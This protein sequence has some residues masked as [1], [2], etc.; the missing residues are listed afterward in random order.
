MR[1][2]YVVLLALTAFFTNSFAQKGNNQLGGGGD[3]SIPTGDFANEFKTGFGFYLKGLLGVGK[4]G[5]ITL[6]SGFSAFKESGE[7]D[8]FTTTQTIVPLLIGYR[9]NFN[10]FFVEPQMGYAMFGNKY[11]SN[12][13]FSTE[14]IGAFTW[15]AGAGYVF[16]NKIE[17]SARYQSSSREGSS[18]NL[19]GLRLGYNFT[20]KSTKK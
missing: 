18:G 15:A 13:G 11:V 5:Q 4:S 9:A 1:K 10:Q 16:N 14:S 2:V 7:W 20:F 17:V 19:F 12:D 6:T 3:L 8:D